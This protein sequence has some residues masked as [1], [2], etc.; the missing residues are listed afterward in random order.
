ML[1]HLCMRYHSG[2]C[3]IEGFPE[4]GF[5]TNSSPTR[6]KSFVVIESFSKITADI[7]QKNQLTTHALSVCT[8]SQNCSGESPM[9]GFRSYS[10]HR[11][12]NSTRWA[13][14]AGSASGLRTEEINS[15]ANSNLSKSLSCSKFGMLVACTEKAYLNFSSHAK[16]SF[17][18]SLVVFLCH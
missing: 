4:C 1:K 7:R 18:G 15:S 2:L 8:R 5:K 16:H 3:L 13:T 6:R 12:S 17:A 11:L 10:S 9:L 14:G